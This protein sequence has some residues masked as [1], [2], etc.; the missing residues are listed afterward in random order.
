MRTRA[1]AGDPLPGSSKQSLGLLAK[2]KG[3]V[4]WRIPGKLP[5]SGLQAP[6]APAGAGLGQLPPGTCGERSP[7]ITRRRREWTPLCRSSDKGWERAPRWA[8]KLSCLS[9]TGI[10]FVPNHLQETQETLTHIF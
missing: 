2:R 7:L 1:G 5:V 6:A 9:A 3:V 4:F 8:R 10:S